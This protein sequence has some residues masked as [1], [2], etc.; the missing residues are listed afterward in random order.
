[1]FCLFLLCLDGDAVPLT[2]AEQAIAMEFTGGEIEDHIGIEMFAV[3]AGLEMEMGGCG[4]SCASRETN[5]LPRFDPIARFH[6]VLGVVAING[7]Q[8]IVMADD[9]DIAISGIGFGHSHQAIECGHDRIIG[10]RL[11]VHP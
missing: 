3:E 10:L 5:W 4:T 8:A 2:G 7:F 11:N 9:D 1:M 6:Q